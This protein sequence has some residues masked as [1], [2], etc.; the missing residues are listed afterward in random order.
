MSKWLLIN[1]INETIQ[2]LIQESSIELNNNKINQ[3]NYDSI[4]IEIHFDH[5]DYANLIAYG[6]NNNGSDYIADIGKV[7][8]KNENEFRE[9]EKHNSKLQKQ[10]INLLKKKLS[11]ITV[12]VNLQLHDD[13][14]IHN[15]K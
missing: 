4:D 8:F 2:K 12:P 5:D 6:T 1:M 10:V 15:I 9:L 7:N 13:L 3:K 14:K 11:Y